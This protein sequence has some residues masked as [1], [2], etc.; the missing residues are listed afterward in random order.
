[1]TIVIPTLGRAQLLGR[2]LDRLAGQRGSPADFEVIVVADAKE[3]DLGSV[4]KVISGRP[5]ALRLLQAGRDGVSAARNAGW[6]AATGELVLFFGDDMLPHPRLLREHLRWHERRPDDRVAVL[7]HVRWARELRLTPFMRWLDHGVQF[8]YPRIRG[9]DAGWGRFYA[10]NVSLKRSLLKRSGGFDE[11]YRFGYE[12]LEL[13]YR[14]NALGLRL[15]YN[16]RAVVEHL[17]PPTIEEWQRRMAVVAG[18]ERRFVAEHP[19]VRPYFFD[20][21]RR[22]QG[23]PRARGRGTRLTGVVPRRVPWLGPR[24]WNS[25]DAYYR[26]ALARAFIDAWEA[27]VA[28]ETGKRAAI[29]RPS[30]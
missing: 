24:V 27:G 4:A 3:Q 22:A 20:M 17:H 21:F 9:T 14:L 6:Q 2:V 25:A 8:D 10:A 1:V 13:A 5:Y 15:L 26:Q 28:D 19:D 12:E 7:G 23:A 18:A 30:R 29:D 11:T 16:R